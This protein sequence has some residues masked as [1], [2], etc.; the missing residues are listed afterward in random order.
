M[1]E[2]RKGEL[3]ILS[4]TFIWGAFPIVTILSYARLSS[5]STLAWSMFF[6]GLF[7]AG[8]MT[9]RK[10]WHELR[11]P[12]LWQY[13]LMAV[14]FISILYYGLYF[15][16]LTKTTAGNAGII[17]L[18]EIFTSYVFF[19][20]IRK[21]HIPFEHIVGALLMIAGAAI[22][23]SPNFSQFNAGDMLVLAA[24]FFAPVGNFFTQK[25]RKIASSESIMFLRCA[26]TV[27]A[28]ILL[29]YALSNPV[30][31]ADARSAL[32]FLLLNGIII[33]GASKLMWVEGIHRI[34]VTKALSLSSIAPLFT[35]LFAWIF[36]RQSPTGW[37]LISLAPMILGVF[38]LTDQLKIRKHA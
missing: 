33:F 19:H 31:F 11:N 34:S 27:P 18:F 21:D 24:T 25:A 26:L 16:G 22:V 8:I 9:Y 36:L 13:V 37:Q 6:A 32:G 3:I 28:V 1:T 23:L 15:T 38:M 17:A 14:L 4:Q 30:S 29:S 10:T 2:Q 5:W 35:L 12:V 7:F 20:L